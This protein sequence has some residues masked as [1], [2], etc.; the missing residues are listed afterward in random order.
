MGLKCA[1][2]KEGFKKAFGAFEEHYYW[3]FADEAVCP[4]D[5]NFHQMKTVLAYSQR[6][7][8]KNDDDIDDDDDPLPCNNG[9]GTLCPRDGLEKCSAVDG[10]LLDGK[11]KEFPNGKSKQA[12]HFLSW[13]WNYKREAVF[14]MLQIMILENEQPEEPFLWWCFFCNNQWR[15]TET[16]TFSDLS[17]TFGDN[18]EGVSKRGGKMVMMFNSL[19]EPLYAKR[20]WCIYEVWVACE[21]DIDCRVLLPRADENEMTGFETLEQVFKICD[22]DCESAEATTKEDKDGITQLIKLKTGSFGEVNQKVQQTLCMK[23]LTE[24]SNCRAGLSLR[25]AAFF[26]GDGDDRGS[27]VMDAKPPTNDDDWPMRTLY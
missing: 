22:T 2:T 7:D 3:E 26:G 10:V 11:S 12:T 13:C 8:D 1:Q 6:D 18:L 24:V 21:K 14:R 16:Q 25:K 15:F 4:P 9:K 19:T 17:E 20:L 27:G 5:P 23:V